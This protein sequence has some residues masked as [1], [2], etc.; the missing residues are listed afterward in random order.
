MRVERSRMS[1]HREKVMRGP[2]NRLIRLE[3][4]GIARGFWRLVATPKDAATTAAVVVMGGLILLSAWHRLWAIPI[5]PSYLALSLLSL[6]IAATAV[7]SLRWRRAWTREHGVLA[8]D[9]LH[10]PTWLVYQSL[11]YSIVAFVVWLPIVVLTAHL[12]GRPA[13]AVLVSI[14]VLVATAAGTTF[15]ID[16]SNHRV[17]VATPNHR[18]R[19]HAANRRDIALARRIGIDLRRKSGWRF[20]LIAGFA[21]GFS[22][23]MVAAAGGLIESV[24]GLTAATIVVPLLWLTR[25]D[26]DLNAGMALAGV[27]R[28]KSARDALL[29]AAAF[30]FAATAGLC[31][32][33]LLPAATKATVFLPTAAF[34]PFAVLYVLRAWRMPRLNRRTADMLACADVAV[35]ALSAVIMPWLTPF[36]ITLLVWRLHRKATLELS[37][38]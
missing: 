5:D 35:I 21:A 13:V 37:L 2:R 22:P 16:R 33:F 15:V 34:V 19:D 7:K 26:A 1:K 18:N 9:A 10:R 11:S 6:P 23:V 3:A 30:A 14:L 38:L 28:L 4:I 27:P 17:F 31:G 25:Q 12:S 36:V 20:L 24:F 32:L 8:R 29:P